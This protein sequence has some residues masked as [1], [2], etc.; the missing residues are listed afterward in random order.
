ML[1]TAR[2]GIVNNLIPVINIEQLSDYIWK[3]EIMKD[4]A[5]LQDNNETKTVYFSRKYSLD[6]EIDKMVQEHHVPA[7]PLSYEFW[8]IPQEKM[9][10]KWHSPSEII[11]PPKSAGFNKRIQ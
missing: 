9:L 4:I 5:T 7:G 8:L 10:F 3:G 1:T 11:I 2:I 6:N